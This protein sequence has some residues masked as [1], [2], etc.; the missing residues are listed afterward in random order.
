MWFDF[1]EIEQ[2][3]PQPVRSKRRD[4]LNQFSQLTYPDDLRQPVKALQAS[5]SALEHLQEPYAGGQPA[6]ASKASVKDFEL[7]DMDAA[8]LSLRLPS[9][10]LDA[11]DN[12]E[13]LTAAVAELTRE[14]QRLQD[15]PESERKAGIKRLLVKWHPDKNQD[16]EVFATSVFQ[17]LQSAL[18]EQE[19][20]QPAQQSASGMDWSSFMPSGDR[21]NFK[22]RPPP[23]NSLPNKLSVNMKICVRNYWFWLLEILLKQGELV[24]AVDDA[25][26]SA[27]FY[28]SRGLRDTAGNM[29]N[30]EFSAWA[31]GYGGLDMLD[32]LVEELGSDVNLKD[33]TGKTPLFEAVRYGNVYACK[34]LLELRA[35]IS[36]KTHEGIT[37]LQVARTPVQ[38]YLSM[39]ETTCPSALWDQYEE[40]VLRDRRDIEKILLGNASL[41]TDKSALH[42][43]FSENEIVAA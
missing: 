24:N 39:Q 30:L 38:E 25:G 42:D 15:L 13:D 40:S 19:Q 11:S 27:I 43:D 35:D 22:A 33:T 23:A 37:A 9:S 4:E 5:A 28:A 17:W 26:R 16:R 32:L 18:L 6:A 34:K 31:Q 7:D 1:A 20:K 8:A 29:E 36:L 10:P 41:T 12:P 14:L 21:S 2:G 3:N